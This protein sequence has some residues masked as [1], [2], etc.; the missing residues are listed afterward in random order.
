MPARML[1]VVV[2]LL[3]VVGVSS[4][5][6]ARPRALHSNSTAWVRAAIEPH[7]EAPEPKPAVAQPSHQSEHSWLERETESSRE[8]ESGGVDS[9]KPHIS[10]DDQFS[11]D[12]SRT[13]EDRFA[14]IN[15]SDASAF[16]PISRI[17]SEAIEFHPLSAN[18]QIL[19]VPEPSSILALATF[20]TAMLGLSYRRKRRL[21]SDFH[22]G[23]ILQNLDD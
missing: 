2:I 3:L 6:D 23:E 1:Q 22:P 8:A 17:S 11:V 12:T 9:N 4:S 16:Q 21:S 14:P 18:G 7:Q 10:D 15:Q 19:A 5:A 20:A 13:K